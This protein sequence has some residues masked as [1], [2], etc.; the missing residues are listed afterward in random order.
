MVFD[1]VTFGA[2]Q[3]AMSVW[4]ESFQS[5]VVDHRVASVTFTGCT[6]NGNWIQNGKFGAEKLSIQNCT[7]NTHENTGYKNNSNPIWIQNLGQC[8][9]TIEGCTVNAV[10][11][12][13]LWE[14]NASGTVAIRNNTFN[15]SNFADAAGDDIYKNVAVM[16]CGT[17]ESVK[18]GNVEISGNTVTGTATGFIS[19]YDNL[20]Q[21]PS[22]ND[23]AT[24][25]LYD[26]TLNGVE[27]S[28]IWKSNT[29]WKP[30]YVTE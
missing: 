15:M 28:V 21:Y 13:K 24:F 11:P 4:T 29:V 9:V 25:R 16:F 10:R 17:T 27:E 5:T 23:G 7:F 6:F 18:L 22:M 19:F 3:M 26:N 12:F 20:T 2:G 1:K 30:T 8:N 14:G